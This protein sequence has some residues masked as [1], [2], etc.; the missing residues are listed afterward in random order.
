VLLDTYILN[1][2]TTMLLKIASGRFCDSVKQI[3]EFSKVL[4]NIGKPRVSPDI[5]HNSV[6]DLRDDFR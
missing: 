6:A 1:S 4:E 3:A 5:H 2:V